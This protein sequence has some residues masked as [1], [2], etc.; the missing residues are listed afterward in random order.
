MEP[1]LELKFL[2]Y[3]HSPLSHSLTRSA[4]ILQS[5][6]VISSLDK[7][8]NLQ[9]LASKRNFAFGNEASGNT[10]A[11]IFEEILKVGVPLPYMTSPLLTLS[12]RS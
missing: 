10:V 7:P 9:L 12:S 2:V 8:P 5:S 3:E 6:P 11:M 1:S 4:D